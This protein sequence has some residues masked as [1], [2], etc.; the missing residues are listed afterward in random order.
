MIEKRP[1]GNKDSF[2]ITSEPEIK[3]TNAQPY[4]ISTEG[5][6]NREKLDFKDFVQSELEKVWTMLNLLS[7]GTSNFTAS[8]NTCCKS[9]FMAK[10]GILRNK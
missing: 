10:L 1:R 2:Y 9:T 8:E 5:T 7:K 3:P 6:I 4:G